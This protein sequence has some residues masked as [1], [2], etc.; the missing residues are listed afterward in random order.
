[1]SSADQRRTLDRADVLVCAAVLAHDRA[2]INTPIS[3]IGGAL[4]ARAAGG[5]A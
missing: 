5:N 1:M 2:R 3:A 4:Q